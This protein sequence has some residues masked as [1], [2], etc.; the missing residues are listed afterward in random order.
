MKLI[1]HRG[2]MNG[3]DPKLE[4]HPDQIQLALAEGFDVEIDVW[5][6]AD[7][8]FMLG[9]D[10][11]T[12]SVPISFLEDCRF[13]LHAKNL[14]ALILIQSIKR[15][16][17]WHENDTHTLTSKG[18]VW[19]SPGK[20]TSST[21]GIQVMPEYCMHPDNIDFTDYVLRPCYGICSDYVAKIR[22]ML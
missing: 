5:Y 21:H 7:T 20:G 15:N 1:A 10:E 16:V 3:P 19:T 18:Y 6:H 12:Y 11:P 8:G 2:L 4:N 17:F 9:H 22:E 14:D 13:W